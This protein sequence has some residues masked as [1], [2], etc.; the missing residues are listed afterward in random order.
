MA[1]DTFKKVRL[2]PNEVQEEN[3]K[4]G[5]KFISDGFLRKEII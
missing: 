5:G 3:Y 1:Y 2:Y 4:S